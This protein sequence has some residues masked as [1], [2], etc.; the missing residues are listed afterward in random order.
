MIKKRIHTNKTT[1]LEELKLVAQ[2][3]D[4]HGRYT[5]WIHVLEQFGLWSRRGN[6]EPHYMT[7]IGAAYTC[8]ENLE[9]SKP[10]IILS[11]EQAM[12]LNRCL[13]YVGGLNRVG[14]VIFKVIYVR[15][16]SM[17]FSHWNPAIKVAMRQARLPVRI[18][19][20]SS[21][22]ADFVDKLRRKILTMREGDY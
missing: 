13:S 15:D 14:M 16:V 5:E 7:P 9:Q 3:R 18:E 21:I 22:L 20:I 2:M 6:G 10:V 11:D 19:I 17:E 1:P 12:Y 8:D 4:E